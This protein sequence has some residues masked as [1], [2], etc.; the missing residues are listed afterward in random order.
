MNF[1]ISSIFF[2]LQ[3]FTSS[4]FQR[5]ALLFFAVLTNAFGAYLEVW[6]DILIMETRAIWLIINAQILTLYAQRPIVEKHAR[7]ALYHPSAEACASMLTD[8]PYK[9]LNALISNLVLYFMTHLR[10]E[11]GAFFFY[12]L[13][14]FSL[15]LTMSVSTDVLSSLRG[16]TSTDPLNLLR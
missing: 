14:A 4:F 7:Y 16:V 6:L 11:A 15:Q 2:N 9:I 12:F 5:G 8:L 10:R 1:I 3:P 13:I